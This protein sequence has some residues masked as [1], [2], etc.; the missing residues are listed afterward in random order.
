MDP[1]HLMSW[2]VLSAVVVHRTEQIGFLKTRFKGRETSPGSSFA[3]RLLILCENDW[4]GQ[5]PAVTRV[6]FLAPLIV[7]LGPTPASKEAAC[8]S[9]HIKGPRP[10]PALGKLYAK[11]QDLSGVGWVRTRL[12]VL[13][14]QNTWFWYKHFVF[15]IFL[16]FWLFLHQNFWI[17]L[18]NGAD[19]RF[20]FVTSALYK[21]QN[22]I[23]TKLKIH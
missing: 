18:E 22:F 8:H 9:L 5:R 6:R 20:Y 19:E 12:D 17:I 11:H 2:F 7:S 15:F 4:K 1:S 21:I 14:Y 23:K 16:Y 3:E 10:R 13:H